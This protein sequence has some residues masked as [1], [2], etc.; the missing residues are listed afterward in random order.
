MRIGD[1]YRPLRDVVCDELRD[2]ILRGDHASGTHLVED[3][4]ARRLGVSRNPVREALR[5]LEAEGFVELI[6]RKGAVVARLSD[7]EVVEIFEVR[8]AL[9]ALA[10]ELAAER[11]DHNGVDELLRILDAARVALD[12][13]DRGAVLDFNTAF[14]EYVL[15][16][17]GNGYLCDVMQGLRGR[18]QWI[19]SRTSSVSRGRDSL[20]EHLELARAIQTGD[21]KRAAKLARYHVEQAARTYWG[22]VEY[23]R[24]AA[25]HDDEQEAPN[26]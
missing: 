9:E 3:H 25:G 23:P 16:L 21:T 1:S 7:S 6:P 2:Q 19:F 12:R 22:T 24:L 18:M 14:H 26:G 17:A 5:M 15:D 11:A 8:M 4:L 10:A 20:D 13:D